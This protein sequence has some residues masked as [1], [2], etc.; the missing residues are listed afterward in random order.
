MSFERVIIQTDLLRSKGLQTFLSFLSHMLQC[1][2][3]P[4]SLM[5]HGATASSQHPCSQGKAAVLC[6]AQSPVVSSPP[7][8]HSSPQV[9]QLGSVAQH[10]DVL[11]TSLDLTDDLMLGLCLYP[12]HSPG[13]TCTI[14]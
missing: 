14:G 7:T 3:P 12:S 2:Q 1:W 5:L 13:A 9:F 6:S 4:R 8:L 11:I 10:E